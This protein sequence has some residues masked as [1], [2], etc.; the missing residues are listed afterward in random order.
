[1]RPHI[2][3]E[4]SAYLPEERNAWIGPDVD[5]SNYSHINSRGR[6][7]MKIFRI[8]YNDIQIHEEAGRK[9]EM[10]ERLL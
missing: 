1:L 3:L 9:E 2:T 8:I 6:A 4:A 10:L 5:G 7:L